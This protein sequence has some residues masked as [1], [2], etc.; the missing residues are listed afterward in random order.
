MCFVYIVQDC[1]LEM[2]QTVFRLSEA[3]R[4]FDAVTVL[5]ELGSVR[6]LQALMDPGVR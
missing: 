5:K 4:E 3:K 6:G 2:M 1:W